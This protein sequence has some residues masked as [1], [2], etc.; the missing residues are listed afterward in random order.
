MQTNEGNHAVDIEIREERPGDEAAVRAVNDEAFGQALEG[1]VVD[2]LRAN[3]ASK[4]SLVATQNDQIV[5]HIMYSPATIGGGVEGAALGPMAVLPEV[6]RQGIGSRLIEFG[7][8]HLK[9]SGCPF[10]V[11]LGHAGYYPRFGFQPA[12]TRGIRCEWEVPDEAFMILAL[13]ENSL[14]DV[15]GTAKYRH[16]FSTIT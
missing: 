7:S 2:A 6:Q 15:T 8:S 4:L 16:E 5:G 10:I 11:V 9:E 13:H 1:R 3:R 12:S 14:D